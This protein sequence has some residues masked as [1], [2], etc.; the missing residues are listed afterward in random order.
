[1]NSSRYIETWNYHVLYLSMALV[2]YRTD[3]ELLKP[4]GTHKEA[5]QP[6]APPVGSGLLLKYV[7][8]SLLYTVPYIRTYNVHFLL[9]A[10]ARFIRIRVS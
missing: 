4:S 7:F 8:I 10:A 9:Q 3:T 2:Y 1:M 5:L 6:K